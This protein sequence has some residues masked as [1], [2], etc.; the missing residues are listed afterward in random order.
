MPI[1]TNNSINT[2]FCKACNFCWCIADITRD[3][4]N[5]SANNS[6]NTK[7][8]RYT[9]TY[10]RPKISTCY[11]RIYSSRYCSAYSSYSSPNQSTDCCAMNYSPPLI[12][13]RQSPLPQKIIPWPPLQPTQSL[14]QVTNATTHYLWDQRSSRDYCRNKRTG[15]S[16]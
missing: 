16:R 10:T 7:S 15:L 1:A 13:L 8:S 11:S 4:A 14:Y 5:H 2:M 9:D 6:P 12:L 3:S